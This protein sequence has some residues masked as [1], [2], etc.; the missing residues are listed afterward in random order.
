MVRYFQVS[1]T[2]NIN[3]TQT[4]GKILQNWEN[5]L[6]CTAPEQTEMTYLFRGHCK[7]ISASKE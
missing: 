6:S 5:F 4:F 1:E 2:G 7:K 3:E